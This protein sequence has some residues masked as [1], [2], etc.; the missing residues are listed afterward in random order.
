MLWARELPLLLCVG[1][2]NGFYPNRESEGIASTDFTDADIPGKKMRQAVMEKNLLPGKHLKKGGAL[3]E[4]NA[5]EPFQTCFEGKCGHGGKNVA[6]KDPSSP[7]SSHKEATDP[8]L[9]SHS[10]LHK[11]AAEMATEATK[12]FFVRDEAV[13]RNARAARRAYDNVYE[14]LASFSGGYYLNTKKSQLSKALGVLELSMNAAPVK[15]AHNRVDGSQFSFPVDETL[16]EISVSVKT[17][18]HERFNFNIW[19]PSG[20]PFRKPHMMIDTRNQKVV[21]VSPLPQA[22]R[23]TVSMTP[24]GSYEVEIRGKSL[25]DFTYRIMQKQNDYM[26]P[27]QG[28]PMKGSNY[29]I[30]IKMLGAA[31][32]TQ[33]QRLVISDGLGGPIHSIVLNQTSDALGNILAFAPIHLDSLSPMLKVEGLSPGNLP[34]SRLN[35]NPIHVASIRILPL[36]DQE[37]T[38]LPGGNLEFS[39]QVVNDGSAATFTFNVRDDLGFIQSFRPVQG[40]LRTGESTV[41]TATF[42]APAKSSNFAS[43][44][45]TFTAKTSSSQN[46][47]TLL[48]SVI[49]KTALETEENPPVYHLLQ[50]YMPC[51]ADSQ[52][53]PDC[54]QHTW[55]MTF[56]AEGAEAAVNV[57]IS[58][59]PSALSCHS[60]KEGSNKKLICDFK[61]SCCS[62]LAEVLIS[63]E[64]G[65]VNNFTVDHNTQP[66]TPA[67]I[68]N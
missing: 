59:D 8:L 37:S 60:E 47:M 6:T 49:P 44:L 27:I 14:E 36:A 68:S 18:R 53:R 4:E 2:V 30:S 41:L 40:F 55:N 22:G 20:D 7:G 13:K 32:G 46:Y 15:I 33:M 45:A 23:W 65:N 1:L 12:K 19:Q 26:L 3:K 29:T 58:P 5:T 63:D 38:L 11:E 67:F 61:S 16:T 21:K 34:F 57:Q 10:Y 56:S 42:V 52:Q 54:S 24:R 35:I 43:S 17:L 50:F 66:P 48:I 9:S 39:V 25:L 28:Q 64:N 62:P 51:G 31:R